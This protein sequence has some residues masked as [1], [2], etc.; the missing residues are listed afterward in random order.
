MNSTVKLINEKQL[1]KACNFALQYEK[2]KIRF[3]ASSSVEYY[4]WTRCIQNA[5]SGVDIVSPELSID[6]ERKIENV[7]CQILTQFKKN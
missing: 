5:I 6:S 7:S 1:G 2:K 4:D 3:I